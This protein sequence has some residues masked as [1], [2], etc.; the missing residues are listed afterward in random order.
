MAD[1]TLLLGTVLRPWLL[2]PQQRPSPVVVTPHEWKEAVGEDMDV[3][4]G[5]YV[6]VDVDV[7][8]NR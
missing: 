3:D 6:D 5:V 7:N 2:E 1:H 4:F 8:V